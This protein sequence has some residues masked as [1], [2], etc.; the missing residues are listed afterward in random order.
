MFNCIIWVLK[1][2][3]C[4]RIIFPSTEMVPTDKYVVQQFTNVVKICDS[5]VKH[6]NDFVQ[7][8]VF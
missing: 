7:I 5:F 3:A 8:N 2:Q 4:T 6:V 1:I